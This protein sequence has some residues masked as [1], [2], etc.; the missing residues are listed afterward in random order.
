MISG[1]TAV[2]ARLVNGKKMPDKQTVSIDQNVFM[3][4][5]RQSVLVT[6]AHDGKVNVAAIAW[7]TVLSCKPPMQGFVISRQRYTHQLVSGSKKFIFN[8]PDR[9][10]IT[11]VVKIGSIT[12]RAVSKFKQVDL[13]PI[14]S[15]TWGDDGPP[16][17]AECPV[18]VECEVRQAIDIG[19]STLFAGE[20]VSCS[21]NA[22][23]IKDGLYQPGL[24]EIPY[25]LG[26]H[27][28]VFNN[29]KIHSF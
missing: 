17:I 13:T 29:L 27:D 16:R 25:H 26:G 8:I 12:G 19:D 11:Q 5:P 15:L 9:S 18:H 20:V 23:L 10:I 7:T 3:V 14:P 21:A 1:E 6:S 24:F 2:D 22:A 4:Y 28:F